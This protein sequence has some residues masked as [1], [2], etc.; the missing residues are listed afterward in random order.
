MF[1]SNDFLRNLG[2]HIR[3]FLSGGGNLH[4]CKGH[5]CASVLMHLLGFVEILDIFRD[6]ISNTF[7]PVS[8]VNN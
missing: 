8:N 5:V 7:E 2:F 6:K 1:Q 4:V 3:L